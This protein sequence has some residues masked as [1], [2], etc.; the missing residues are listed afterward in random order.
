MFGI[1]GRG[2]GWMG[3]RVPEHYPCRNY[4]SHPLNVSSFSTSLQLNCRL[5]GQAKHQYKREGEAWEECNEHYRKRDGCEEFRQ[6][7]SRAR[8]SCSSRHTSREST[9]QW[10]LRSIKTMFFFLLTS[11]CNVHRPV[12]KLAI[13]LLFLLRRSGIYLVEPRT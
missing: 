12:R 3:L 1:V 9:T 10:R 6:R 13:T 8:Q 5:F 2:A 4:D 11:V 7:K